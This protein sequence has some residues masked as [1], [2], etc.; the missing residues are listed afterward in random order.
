VRLGP[1]LAFRAAMACDDPRAAIALA[2]ALGRA[3][4]ERAADPATR[5]VGL[6]GVLD[7]LEIVPREELVLADVN[8][9]VDEAAIV[10]DRVLT[11]RGFRHPTPPPAQDGELAPLPSG[12]PPPDDVVRPDSGAP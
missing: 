2:E 6:G 4:A 1:D 8:V 12:E 11:L 3:R 10:V 7:R 9:P 5:V